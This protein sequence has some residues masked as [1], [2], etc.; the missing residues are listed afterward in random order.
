MRLDR[1]VEM[2]KRKEKRERKQ[3]TQEQRQQ[4]RDTSQ[5]SEIVRLSPDCMEGLSRQQAEER[6]EGGWGNEE[7][8]ASSLTVRDIIR[9][10]VCTYFNLIFAVLAVL[11]SITGS[12]RNLTFL[13]VVIINTVVGIVQEVRAKRILD[14][15]NMLNAPHAEVVREGKTQKVAS[16]ELVLDD[17]V[18]FPSGSQVCADAVI[19]QGQVRVNESLLTGESEEIEKKEGDLLLSGS[20]I[21]AGKCRARLDRVGR[22]SYISQLTLQAKAMREGEQSEMIRSLNKLVK[23]A[24]VA[25]IPIGIALFAQSYFLNQ[26]PFRDSILSM[27]AAVIGMIPEG[28]YLLT[29][30]ALTLGTVRL[31]LKKVLLHDMKSME[32]LARVDVLCVDKTGT[33]TEDE[34]EVKELIRLDENRE[35]GEIRESL[36]RFVQAMDPENGTMRALQAG[37]PGQN[38]AKPEAVVP[39]SSAAKYSGAVLDGKSY[40]L[41]APEFVLLEKYETWR[42][43]LEAYSARGYRVLVFGTCPERPDGK[44]LKAGIE[45]LA[46]V[47]LM[48]R[49]REEAPQTF[50]YFAEQ[51]VEIK[52]ISGD[53]PLTVS[54]TAKEAGI[55]NADKYVDTRQLQTEEDFEKA[56]TE[57]TVFGRV[58]PE[59]KRLLVQALKKNGKTVAMT[60]DGVNDVLA[61]KD[62]DCSIAMASGSDAAIQAS[63]VVLLESDFARMPEVVGEG[64][65]VVNNIQQS[66]SLFLVKNIFSFLL[67]L[68]SLC[69]MFQ[70]PLEPSQISLISMFTIGVPGFFLSLQPN[71]EKIQGKFLSN[72]LLKALPAG[73]TDALLVAFLAVCGETFHIG[74]D[75]ISTAATLLLALVGFMILYQICRPMNLIRRLIWWGCAAGLVGS[76]LLVPWLFGLTAISK[77]GV[78]LLVLFLLASDPVFRYLTRFNEWLQEMAG[79]IRARSSQARTEGTYGPGKRNRKNT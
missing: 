12:F 59:Q 79:K 25:I 46:A 32:T 60:G 70:Y 73:V 38:G 9:K 51:G 11:V 75:D 13:P 22:D 50:A 63:Q 48:N 1:S 69:F 10:N 57:Y 39:F 29:T 28:L 7:V 36:T 3:K 23:A 65:R 45:P 66:A 30:M 68:A 72:V 2:R 58:L 71:H 61:L 34:M 20:F 53:N 27:V 67:S 76:V 37:F 26:E 47:V 74:A 43:K 31:A 35:E 14:K 18:I 44:P 6:M 19:C 62:A 33:I 54:E 56:A 78:M 40:V 55:A 15:M 17:I 64:R 5:R 49:I 41:G 24:G 77:Q 8:E 16:T 42:E 4:G 21:T 52:V